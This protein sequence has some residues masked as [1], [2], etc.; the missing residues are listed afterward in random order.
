MA[1]R[2]S[3]EEG[4]L[5]QLGTKVSD[6]LGEQEWFQELRSK[7]DEL[8]PEKQ[9][10]VKIG[11]IAIVALGMVAL[12]GS[13]LMSVNALKSDV[14][15]K[16]SLMAALQ[17]ASDEL[18]RLKDSSGSANAASDTSPWS[19]YFETVLTSANIDPSAYELSNEKQG[20][21]GEQSRESLFDI[22]LKHV[23]VKQVVRFAN[24]LE[25]GPRPVKLK[26]LEVDTKNDPTGY[27][28]A[29]LSISAFKMASQ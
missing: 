24:A 4:R 17:H 12:V 14:S 5:Q 1:P 11:G 21:K 28:D 6:W 23:T 26:T 2:E 19:S 3:N 20:A 18:K 25:A 7:W 13:S 27:M 10:Y 9:L 22:S 16:A 15:N 8:D 29:K